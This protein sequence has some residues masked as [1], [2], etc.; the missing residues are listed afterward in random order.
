ME[1]VRTAVLLFPNQLFAMF[2]D[3]AHTICMIKLM[4]F[5]VIQPIHRLKKGSVVKL[6]TKAAVQAPSTGRTLPEGAES[7]EAA[8]PAVL[9]FP[10]QTFAVDYNPVNTICMISPTSIHG[11]Q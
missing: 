6:R 5:R 1:G 8:R 11:D 3:P 4:I 7:R 10:N 2:S 9:L